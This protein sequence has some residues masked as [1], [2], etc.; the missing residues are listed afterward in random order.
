[1]VFTEISLVNH[2]PSL[3]GGELTKNNIDKTAKVVEIV[4]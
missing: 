3:K 2:T 4:E 1:V